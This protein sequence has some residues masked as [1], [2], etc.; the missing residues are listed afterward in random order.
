[1][2]D[3]CIKRVEG[4]ALRLSHLGTLPDLAALSLA[5]LWGLYRYL[6]RLADSAA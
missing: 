4:L 3:E 6:Q 1:M 2:R 5:D